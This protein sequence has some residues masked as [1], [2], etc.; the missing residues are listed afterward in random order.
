M[1]A[2]MNFRFARRNFAPLALLANTLI[3]KNNPF[4][5]VSF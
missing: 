3:L 1:K 4:A 2:K 5:E